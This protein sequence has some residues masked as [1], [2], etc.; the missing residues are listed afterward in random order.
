MIAAGTSIGAGRL[1]RLQ[2]NIV[3]GKVRLSI[4][5]SGACVALSDLGLFKEPAHLVAPS[6]LRDKE[7]LVSFVTVSPVASIRYTL[8]GT[9]PGVGSPLYKGPFLLE[10]SGVVKA[11]CFEGDTASEVTVKELGLSKSGW[12]VIGPDSSGTA[13]FPQDII[14][15]MGREQTFKAFTYL[16]RQDKRTEGIVDQYVFYI[17]EA[18]VNWKKAAEGEFSNIKSNPIEQVVQLGRVV[19]ACYFKFSALHVVGGNGVV[20][21]ELGGR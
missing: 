7:G 16:P 1:I 21:A 12:R 4:N 19:T 15:D 6:I 17:S 3:T 5:G 18:G 2:Q 11:R 13:K 20:V 9:E 8:D 14:V 10:G